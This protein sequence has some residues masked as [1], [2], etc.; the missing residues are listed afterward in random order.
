ME[1]VSLAASLIALTSATTNA[2]KFFSTLH[3]APSELQRLHQHVR[4]LRS[5]LDLELQFNA[6]Q[7]NADAPG[8]SPYLGLEKTK[9]FESAL[10]N[11]RSCL[12]LIESSLAIYHGK[13]GKIVCG[14]WVFR[15]RTE[16][17]QLVESMHHI[18]QTVMSLL[19]TIST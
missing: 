5:A 1:P 6:G 9:D 8:G 11:A 3:N 12:E 4:Q 19:T 7:L 10:S 15:H 18:E 16:I 13:P 14:R 2:V 17:L